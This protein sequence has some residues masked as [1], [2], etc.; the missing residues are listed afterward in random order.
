MPVRP[1][2]SGAVTGQAESTAA[3]NTPEADGPPIVTVAGV[4]PT[5][6]TDQMVL[7]QNI[8]TYQ[9]AG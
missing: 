3:F 5:T 8:V 6:H 4:T 1:A 9:A 7:D 2:T